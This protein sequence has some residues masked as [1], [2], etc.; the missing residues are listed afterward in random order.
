LP[1]A[2]CRRLFDTYVP[3]IPPCRNSKV[4]RAMAYDELSV[5]YILKK[6]LYED[7]LEEGASTKVSSVE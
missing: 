1:S 4:G 3:Y 6:P 7:T 2:E 5:M